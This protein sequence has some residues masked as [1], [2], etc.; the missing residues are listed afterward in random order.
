MKFD[1]IEML[2]FMGYILLISVPVLGF[3]YLLSVYMVTI[4]LFDV[5][6]DFLDIFKL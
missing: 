6:F 2:K 1:L 5:F 4:R 3:W